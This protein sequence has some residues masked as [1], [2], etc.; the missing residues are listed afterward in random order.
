LRMKTGM[1]C[2]GSTASRRGRISRSPNAQRLF[3][4][5][6]TAVHARRTFHE[7]VRQL[8][9]TQAKD[10]NSWP[11]HANKNTDATSSTRPYDWE[12]PSCEAYHDPQFTG[13][14]APFLEARKRLD[15]HYHRNPAKGRQILQDAILDR[16]V[17]ATQNKDTEQQQQPAR[18]WIVFSAGSMGVGKGYVL[19][20]LHQYGLF[21]LQN[22]LKIDPDMIKCEL[23]ELAGYLQCNP[24]LAATLVHRE[25]TQMADVLLEYALSHG[26]S[27]LIDGSLRNVDYYAS[28]LERIRTEYENYYRIGILHVVADRDVIRQR[29]HDRAEKTGR[30]VPPYV[31]EESMKQV[32]HSVQRLSSWTDAT[33]TIEN[34]ED[35]PLRLVSASGKL[36]MKENNDNNLSWQGFA[37]IWTMDSEDPNDD[38]PHHSSE[39]TTTETTSPGI[40]HMASSWNDAEAHAAARDIWSDAYPNFCPRCALSCDGQCGVC[41]HGVHICA[42]LECSG[43]GASTTT[44]YYPW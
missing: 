3:L 27:T 21:P 28:L 14:T 39:T 30:V 33:F 34:N 26:K 43:Y 9:A 37:R 25:S 44:W 18:P 11:P 2:C 23:P 6:P 29:A 42:C 38:R 32:P 24:A 19:T 7:W 22:F 17:T 8:P 36:L 5:T 31:L 13:Y 40:C 20:K 10:P 35:Q 4:G 16:V 15:Y 41:I 12:Q 1:S